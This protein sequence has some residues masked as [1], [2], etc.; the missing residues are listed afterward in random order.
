MKYQPP[1]NLLFS[2][3]ECKNSIEWPNY[4]ALGFTLEHVPGLIQMIYDEEPNL[5]ESSNLGIW[6][7]V[8]AWRTLGQL[9]AVTAIEPLI[10]FLIKNY[11]DDW[12]FIEIPI[13][14]QL[15][16][17][18]ALMVLTKYLADDSIEIFPRTCFS[19]AIARIG[20]SNPES[21]RVCISLLT[22][23]LA[24]FEKND[25]SLN[26]FIISDLLDLNA[27]E[28][29]ETIKEAYQRTCVDLSIIGD[30]DE[31]KEILGISS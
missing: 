2:Y 16:G 29:F 20:L 25:P 26:G 14:L 28:S 1:L 15:I 27:I 8:H 19:S 23:H 13:V 22:N 30:L 18:P 9:K 31:A 21:R 11:D 6:A 5:N 4:L 12:A 10:Q 17:E 7:P 3:G 24:R